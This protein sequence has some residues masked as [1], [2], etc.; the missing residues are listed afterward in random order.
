VD[1]QKCTK[2]IKEA[3]GCEKDIPPLFIEGIEITRC[4]IKYLTGLEAIYLEVYYAYKNG[5][6]PN[7]GGWL[8]QPMK[9]SQI[10]IFVDKLFTK[11]QGEKQNG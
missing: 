2:Q 6:L 4:P 9:F 5:Y 3:R 8:N 7:I 1:C 11:Y 10:M